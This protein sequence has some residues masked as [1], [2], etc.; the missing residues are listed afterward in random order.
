V[1]TMRKHRELYRAI[2]KIRATEILCSIITQLE[3]G[4]Y[5]ENDFELDKNE[6][7]LKLYKL[8]IGKYSADS[9]VNELLEDLNE[10]MGSNYWLYIPEPS[11][12]II[13]MEKLY[14]RKCNK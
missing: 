8:K 12:L 13:K 10:I 11:D 2:Q 9:S 1:A 4:E 5:D 3:N 7:L 6:I 14:R